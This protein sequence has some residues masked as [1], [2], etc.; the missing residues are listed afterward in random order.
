MVLVGAVKL[1]LVVVGL[2]VLPKCCYC[3]CSKEW[4]LVW[5]VV[6]VGCFVDILSPVAV[7]CLVSDCWKA[8]ML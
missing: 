7:L 4:M 5:E 8:L 3:C 6:L 2:E 1:S